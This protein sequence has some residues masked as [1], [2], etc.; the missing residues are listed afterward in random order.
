MSIGPTP[1][2][3]HHPAVA[4]L[5]CLRESS[6]ADRGRGLA[7]LPAADRYLLGRVAKR[8]LVLSIMAEALDDERQVA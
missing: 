1:A 6:L 3:A 2:P 8:R 4:H 7:R 5:D